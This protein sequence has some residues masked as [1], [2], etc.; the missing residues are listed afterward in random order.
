MPGG[1]SL[2]SAV[3][4]GD[5]VIGPRIVAVLAQWN[6]TTAQFFSINAITYLFVIFAL[7][8]VKIPEFT[9]DT[10][11]GWRRFTFAFKIAR[12]RIVVSRLVLTLAS[13]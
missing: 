10:T 6:V 11:A 8:S 13:F 7:I 2:K 9:R 5:R 3:I 1:M 12:E 4:K